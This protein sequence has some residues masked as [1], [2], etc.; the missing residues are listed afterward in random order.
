MDPTPEWTG[1]VP[2]YAGITALI[3]LVA[4]LGL[5]SILAEI[6]GA[7]VASGM[8]QV[9]SNRQVVQHP[10]GGVVGAIEVEK[11][12]SVKKGDVLIRLDG[13]RIRSEL[14]ITESQLHEIAT[15]KTRLMAE[16]DGAEALRFDQELI[17]HARRNPESAQIVAGEMVLFNARR[18]A[19]FQEV[20]LLE[21]QNS[22]IENRIEGITAQMDAIQLQR[23]LVEKELSY[24]QQLLAEQLT[25][26]SLVN[27]LMRNEA[28]LQGRAG[29]LEAEIAEL[30]GKIAG[31][32]IAIL[33]LQTRRR[34]EAVTTLRDLQF[35]EIELNERRIDLRET[36][37]RLDVRAPVDGIVYD[38]Q[39]FAI[40]SVVQPAEPLM[41]II[42]QDQPLIV[43]ARIEA[44]N[45]DEV[46]VG[47]EAVLI[48][49]AFDQRE[50][51]ELRGR[52]SSISADVITDE[53]TGAGYYEAEI[54]LDPGELDKLQGETLVPGMPVEA[55]LQTGNRTPLTYLIA[56][57]TS[58]FNKS[59]REN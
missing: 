17:L 41:Y 36:L 28:D 38:L 53:I 24:Q 10:E 20:T 25:Q 58:F 21:E 45:V 8:V 2:L 29:Q 50:V 23:D 9:E 39:V 56:P 12:Q 31:N 19:L 43:S 34:E 55:F 32:N 6:S 42:P 3:A 18:A 22:Q 30:R 51:P 52:I 59:F 11:S 46:Y 37:S 40:Q 47:Q 13:R 26:A 5:W 33:Q 14:A 48:L 15:R 54:I 49:P 27:E 7:V 16:R 1:N 44:I 35:R 4:G 57:F